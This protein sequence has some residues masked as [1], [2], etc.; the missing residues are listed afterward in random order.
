MSRLALAGF[1]A[2]A[3]LLAACGGSKGGSDALEVSGDLLISVDLT[4]PDSAGETRQ[5]LPGESLDPG[6]ADTAPETPACVADC[7]KADDRQ[8]APNVQGWYQVCALSAAGCLQWGTATECPS[9]QACVGGTCV[10]TCQSDPGCTKAGDKRCSA[11]AAYQECS[12]VSAGCFKLGTEQACPGA[13]VCVGDGA[14]QCQDACQ[15]GDRK[16]FSAQA[17]LYQACGQDVAGCKVWGTPTSCGTDQVC[18]GA[19]VCQAVCTSDCTKEGDLACASAST[20]KLCMTVQPGCL[21]YGDPASCPGALTCNAGNCEVACTSDA[22]CTA[23]GVV[24]CVDD[25]HQHACAQAATDCLKWDVSAPCPLHQACGATGCACADACQDGQAACLPDVDAHYRQFCAQDDSGCRYWKYED[26]GGGANCDTGACVQLCG[27]D[28]GCTAAGVTRCESLGSFSTCAVV[29]GHPDCIQFG[30]ATACA[31]HQDC[32]DATGKC[33]CRVEDGCTAAAQKRCIDYDNAATCTADD[34]GCL[35]WGAP[36]PCPEGDTCSGGTCGPICVSDLDCTA[37]GLKRCTADGLQQ[38]CVEVQAGCIKWAPGQACPSHE[39]CVTGT[40]CAC[41]AGCKAAESRCVGLHQY[42]ACAPADAQGC[43][44]WDAAQTCS[45]TDSC[46]QGD[47]RTVA[48]PVIACGSITLNLVNQGYSDVSVSGNFQGPSWVTLPMTLAQ[49]IWSATVQVSAAG[50]YDYKFIADGTWVRDPLNPAFDGTPPLDNSVATVV[51]VTT[52]DSAGATRCTTAGTLETCTLTAQCLQWQAP[53]DPCD[54][55]D[56][57]CDQGVCHA[58]QSPVVTDTTVTFTLRDQGQDIQ[59]AGDF[60]SPS[61]GAYLPLDAQGP[62]RVLVLQRASMPGLTTGKHLY[63]FRPPSGVWFYDPSNP[64]KEDDGQGGFN[65]IL[66]IPAACASGC[67]PIGDT[68]CVDE[69]DQRLCQPDGG[70]DGCGGW[71]P[72]A[73][74]GGQYCLRTTCEVFPVVNAAAKTV[75]FVVPDSLVGAGATRVVEVRG[76]FTTPAWD[77]TTAVPLGLANGVWTGQSGALASGSWQYK[78]HIV[79]DG[80][81]TWMA[82]PHDPVQVDDT[83][84]GK[85]SVFVVP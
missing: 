74:Q 4:P 55:P 20:Y 57:Y 9:D 42:Q 38:E 32:L 1:L 73:C 58:I 34:Q 59:L 45:G 24:A 54:E 36:E 85:N 84:G 21:K 71:S 40:G 35:F 78:V 82:D 46:V 29:D 80:V 23:V 76:D 12:E 56:H 33:A 68:Q 66:N 53:A 14:C 3:V 8:C 79:L 44:F 70:T 16:C 22:G 65:S 81:E 49:G 61:W 48:S 77:A 72:S 6:A 15:D 17:D 31:V 83:Y 10:A 63:K 7:A 13:A 11:A 30:A 41:Q 28:P 43:T 25:A 52:C 75:L 2:S 19:G 37:A 62:V 69:G 60:T 27:S 39:A 26:C 64:L 18:Q 50:T 47:C 67:T 51:A 5:D